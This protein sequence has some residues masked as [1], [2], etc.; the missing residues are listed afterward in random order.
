M[1]RQPAEILE[2]A[3]YLQ[4]ELTAL[5]TV[6]SAIPHSEKP[7]GET[8][9]LEM[10]L[11]IDHAQR[12]LFSP[13]IEGL[14]F[15]NTVEAAEGPDEVIDSIRENRSTLVAMLGNIPEAGWQRSLMQNGE[16]TTLL[17]RLHS[18][19]GFEREKLKEIAERI[20]VIDAGRT[21]QKPHRA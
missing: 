17:D 18:L 10:L 1:E 2:Q 6:I 20:L 3:S 15:K 12:T 13:L 21:L 14:A 16:E 4:E 19:I 11:G 5:K 8:S 7:L 9:V